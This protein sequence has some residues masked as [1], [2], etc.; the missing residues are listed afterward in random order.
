MN[1]LH[2]VA[3]LSLIHRDLKSSNGA[4]RLRNQLNRAR[5]TTC[6]QIFNT[7]VLLNRPIVKDN[8]AGKVMKI[9]DFGLAREIYKTT[10]MSSQ[11]G[12]YAWM[13]RTFF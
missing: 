6:M 12:T 10:R 7:A 3:P 11:A 8:W 1:Y 9:T 5:L 2:Y 4:Y 13:V